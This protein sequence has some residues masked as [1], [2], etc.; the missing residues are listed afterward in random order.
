M[1]AA[2]YLYKYIEFFFSK[3]DLEIMLPPK[4]LSYEMWLSSIHDVYFDTEKKSDEFHYNIKFSPSYKKIMNYADEIKNIREPMKN[5]EKI[6]ELKKKIE[7]QY[8]NL[9]YYQDI[10]VYAHYFFESMK[11]NNVFTMDITGGGITLEH[12]KQKIRDKI[13]ELYQH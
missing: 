2:E 6:Y 3:E 8:K 12:F 11:I 5:K 7:D 1:D 10:Y 9:Y 13:K 4:S